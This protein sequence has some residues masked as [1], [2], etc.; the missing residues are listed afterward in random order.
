MKAK[1]ES[2]YGIEKISS[3]EDPQKDH[4][5]MRRQKQR[6]QINAAKEKVLIG[7]V[8]KRSQ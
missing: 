3:P 5:T 7:F 6:K 8:P 2:P 4:A 1:F